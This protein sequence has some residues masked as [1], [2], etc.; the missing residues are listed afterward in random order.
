MRG[1]CIGVLK[2]EPKKMAK[3]FFLDFFTININGTKRIPYMKWD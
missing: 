3:H 1:E 2:R